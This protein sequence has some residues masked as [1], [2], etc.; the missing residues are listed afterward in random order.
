MARRVDYTR[1]ERVRAWPRALGRANS[2]MWVWGRGQGYSQVVVVPVTA[3][4]RSSRSAHARA[5][6]HHLILPLCAC[7][8]TTRCTCPLTIKKGKSGTQTGFMVFCRHDCSRRIAAHY[9]APRRVLVLLAEEERGRITLR[10]R[11][12]VFPVRLCLCLCLSPPHDGDTR[13][14]CGRDAPHCISDFLARRPLR[15]LI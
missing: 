3:W 1:A 9:S 2:A 10:L 7:R 5:R 13:G 15:N 12:S 6:K 8:S 11:V 4:T 14:A